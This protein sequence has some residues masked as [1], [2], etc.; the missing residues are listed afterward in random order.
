MLG[1]GGYREDFKDIMRGRAVQDIISKFHN[2]QHSVDKFFQLDDSRIIGIYPTA[3]GVVYVEVSVGINGDVN[4][5][6]II[7][8]DFCWEYE[9]INNVELNW[10]EALDGKKIN[11]GKI[12]AEQVKQIL[13]REKWYN[14]P[15]TLC[16]PKKMTINY[17]IDLCYDLYQEELGVMAYWMAILQLGDD[18]ID[19]GEIR[20]CCSYRPEDREKTEVAIMR[21]EN[22]FNLYNGFHRAG[23]RLR[24][25]TAYPQGGGEVGDALAINAQQLQS[26]L[27]NPQNFSEEDVIPAIFSTYTLVENVNKHLAF[28]GYERPSTDY[29]RIGVA[30]MT[31]VTAIYLF[32]L[33]IDLTMLYQ[34]NNKLQQ[35]ETRLILLS[36]ESRAY[37]DYEQMRLASNKREQ[38]LMELSNI[39]MPWYNLM[40]YLGTKTIVGVRLTGIKLADD[41]AY[42]RL[43]EDT[44][45]NLSKT[46]I[47]NEQNEAE[48][49]KS[50]KTV[51]L[52]GIARNYEQI[53]EYMQMLNEI[54]LFQDK[55]ELLEATIDSNN[56][57][58]E[59]IRFIIRAEII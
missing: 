54:D 56:Q 10:V 8:D 16:L 6:N 48:D 26:P 51:I 7:R 23:L 32:F 28:G 57:G 34:T 29:R 39:S 9:D 30:I 18:K 36:N 38:S 58:L 55:V 19:V 50:V 5:N 47:S 44:I 25:I 53:S 27:L 46:D 37:D 17:I 2:C 13:V 49:N 21:E 40:V 20:T 35:A 15:L 24:E 33:A 43:L 3:K 14:L 52:H 22:L 31:V 4:I 11:H 41:F 45:A 1:L 59:N 12:L 42:N